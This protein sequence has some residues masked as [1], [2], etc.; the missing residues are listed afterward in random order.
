MAFRSLRSLSRL[1]CCAAAQA[2]LLNSIS[3]RLCAVVRAL[4]ASAHEHPSSSPWPHSSCHA[5]VAVTLRGAML[6]VW[7]SQ[8][9]AVGMET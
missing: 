2:L 8:E 1:P 3:C 9:V 4:G 6:R 5:E 7:A